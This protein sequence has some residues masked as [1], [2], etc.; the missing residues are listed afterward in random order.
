MQPTET[1]FLGIAYRARA[2][3]LASQRLINLFPEVVESKVGASV[4]GFFGCPGTVLQKEIGNG[5]IRG[6]TVFANKLYVVS[7]NTV[8][9][10]DTSYNAS[11]LGTIG[12][13]S[14]IVTFMNNATQ[15][16]LFDSLGGWTIIAGVL[17]AITL[18][19]SNPG[20]PSYQDGFALCPEVGT[21][22]LWQSNLNDFTT[23]DP[24]NFTTEDGTPDNIVS[25][26]EF[27]NQVV[28]FKEKSTCFYINAGNPGFA[29]QRL[30]GVYP[31]TGC[32]A[33][34]SPAVLNE[35][36]VWLGRNKDGVGTVYGMRGYEPERIST[37]AL[38]YAIN[39]YSTITDAIAFT[40][41]LEGHKFYILNFPSG[42]ETWALDIVEMREIK[43]PAWH[44]RAAFSNGAF[45]IYPYQC[46]TW[47]NN[48]VLVGDSSVGNIYALDLT[49]FQDNGS[50][51]KWLRS[52]PA[53]AR[54]QYSPVRYNFLELEGQTG[55]GSD[56]PT[57]SLRYSDDGGYNWSAELYQE[58]GATGDYGNIVRWNR[59]GQTRRGMN[60]QRIFELSGT[61]A[62]PPA[63]YGATLG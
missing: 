50:L 43:L 8:Y 1:P 12:T 55:T 32:V 53:L 58:Q 23:W 16:A 48:K 17:A 25:T 7:G 46:S 49:N 34:N 51:R 21:F 41:V 9:S 44:Q 28:L 24:L 38:E 27:H 63:L 56:N 39:Q 30:Q 37:H 3:S 31:N 40:T 15:I 57:L 59:L 20:V 18:P 62:T 19:F 42:G 10:L 14:G 2:Q 5:P 33:A 26:L 11:S 35:T 60:Q 54:D 36:V 6:M 22:N 29:F 13:S 61:S 47:F 45:T 4:A 52:W